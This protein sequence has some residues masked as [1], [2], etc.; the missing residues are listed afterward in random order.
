MDDSERVVRDL[1]AEGFNPE[2]YDVNSIVADLR[3]AAR[4]D[5]IDTAPDEAWTGAAVARHKRRTAR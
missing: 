2:H 4:D 1:R 3:A 5:R